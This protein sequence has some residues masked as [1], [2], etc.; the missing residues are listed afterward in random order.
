MSIRGRT[1]TG[2]GGA[3]S[4]RMPGKLRNA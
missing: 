1:S 2:A 3:A 4:N